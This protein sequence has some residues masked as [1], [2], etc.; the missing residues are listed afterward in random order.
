MK[1]QHNDSVSKD[2]AFF[3]LVFLSACREFAPMLLIL[4]KKSFLGSQWD[5]RKV[6]KPTAM[7]RKKWKK[8]KNERKYSH[9]FCSLLVQG[10]KFKIINVHGEK[11][12]TE[13]AKKETE[14]AKKAQ[15]AFPPDAL[16]ERQK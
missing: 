5:A 2:A 13:A 3:P 15:S 6:R 16:N 11:K 1:Q 10:F 14:A 7:R 8:D 9:I 4:K 12:E